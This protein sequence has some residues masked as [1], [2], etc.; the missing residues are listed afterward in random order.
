MTPER[1][2]FGLIF[3]NFFHLK[4]LPKKYPPISEQI[5]SIINQINKKN[6][7]YVSF[8]KN[9]ID[10]NEITRTMSKNIILNFLLK[11]EN[12]SKLPNIKIAYKNE[13]IKFPP[14]I[15]KKID[16][17]KIIIEVNILFCKF[18]ICYHNFFLLIDNF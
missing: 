15:I 18:V 4:T 9:K 17:G 2:L 13:T 1:V 14:L 10:S 3:V 12:T 11:T 7:A 6:D 8:L 16:T 5:V